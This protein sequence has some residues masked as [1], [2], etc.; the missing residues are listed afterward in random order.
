MP[1]TAA[2]EQRVKPGDM[3]TVLVAR[4][5]NAFE[6]VSTAFIGLERA[7]APEATAIDP[8][9]MFRTA[10]QFRKQLGE[11]NYKKWVL[12][13]DYLSEIFGA[14]VPDG[15][16]HLYKPTIALADILLKAPGVDAITYPSVAT[17]DQGINV[18]TILFS[19]PPRLG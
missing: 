12:V 8:A 6:R 3:V 19:G 14:A 4:T 16:V 7:R 1:N 10:P 15:E 11:G 9:E 13:D 17:N 2:I 5:R 18:C